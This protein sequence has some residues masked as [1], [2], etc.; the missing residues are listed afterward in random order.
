MWSKIVRFF[1]ASVTRF[2]YLEGPLNIISY[3]CIQILDSDL[4]GSFKNILEGL[5]HVLKNVTIRMVTLT[6]HKV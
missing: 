1:G 3:T 5:F 6:A 2:G 4:F